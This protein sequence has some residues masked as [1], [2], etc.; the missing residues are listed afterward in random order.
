MNDFVGLMN[1]NQEARNF[2][3]GC[4]F[5][6]S[7]RNAISLLLAVIS[8][9]Q[10]GEYI[11]GFFA[12]YIWQYLLPDVKFYSVGLTD[13]FYAIAEV[14]N[15]QGE[16]EFKPAEEISQLVAEQKTTAFF[17]MNK[18][19]HCEAS[20]TLIAEIDQALEFIVKRYA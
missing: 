9:P 2:D 13:N 1:V 12:L 11:K 17:N 6:P 16:Y 5:N 15:A 14:L 19:E 8:A 4:E 10:K 20:Q 18:S 7:Q 3:Y